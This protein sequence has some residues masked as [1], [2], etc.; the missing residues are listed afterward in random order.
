MQHVS[1]IYG[2]EGKTESEIWGHILINEQHTPWKKAKWNN[3]ANCG[4][5]LLL[6]NFYVIIT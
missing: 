3:I 4:T 2:S 6:I 5:I 1:E